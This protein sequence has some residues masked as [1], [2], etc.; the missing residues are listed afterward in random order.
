MVSSALV[1]MRTEMFIAPPVR[2]HCSLVNV[3]S[4]L[5]VV[6]PN[7]DQL[8][9]RQQASFR[10]YASFRQER[11]TV[12][13]S[14]FVGSKKLLDPGRRTLMTHQE[15]APPKST[16]VGPGPIHD[17]AW[18]MVSISQASN[19]GRRSAACAVR[20]CGRAS[21]RP[22][23]APP[24]GHGHVLPRVYCIICIMLS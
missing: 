22:S 17:K 9:R 18:E 20:L 16:T 23:S 6:S 7:Q 14:I 13:L 12:Q 24:E 10:P 3:G 4:T 1:T 8:Y 19:A 21:R 15:R 5:V 11:E 2:K